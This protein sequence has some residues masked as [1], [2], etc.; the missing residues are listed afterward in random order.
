MKEIEDSDAIDM[1]YC[2]EEYLYVQLI[3]HNFC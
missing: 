2:W 3:L 1:I